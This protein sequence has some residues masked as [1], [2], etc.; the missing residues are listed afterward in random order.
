ML[1]PLKMGD[2]A[3]EQFERAAFLLSKRAKSLQYKFAFRL[4]GLH[5]SRI[6]STDQKIL[7]KSFKVKFPYILNLLRSNTKVWPF[8]IVIQIFLI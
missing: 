2:V 4:V 8:F 5:N 1:N 6:K 7:L 3:I